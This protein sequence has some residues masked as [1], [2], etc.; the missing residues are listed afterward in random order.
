MVTLAVIEIGLRF[1]VDHLAPERR[2]P[3]SA[4]SVLRSLPGSGRVYGLRPGIAPPIGINS[5]GFRGPDVSRA[6]PA[7]VF[8]I[9]M[10]GDSITYGNSVQWDQTFSWRLEEQ[11]NRRDTGLRFE[12]LNLGV[13]GYN[14]RQELAALRELGL[15]LDPDLIVLNVCLN[16]SDPEKEMYGIALK[17][18]TQIRSWSDIN[19]RTIVDSSYLLTLTKH[20]LIGLL[21][22]S[23][24]SLK[25]L[26]SPRLF[27]DTRVGETAWAEM[28]A[29]MREMH[30]LAR[31]ARIP[32]AAVIYPYSS[33]L[34]LSDEERVPQQ[35]LLR[36]FR[37]LGVPAMEPIPAYRGA[38]QSMFVDGYIH[39][40]PL[41]H[42]R[43]ARAIQDFLESNRLLPTA[44]AS[45]IEGT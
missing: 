40:S 1:Y 45:R 39:L 3:E 15:Q 31:A 23:A 29:A 6:K 16:D 8:R 33:Q 11:L 34:E 12:V 18:R 26:N 7:G 28:K 21:Q 19:I 30:A 20:E 5:L 22:G 41:G 36:F 37:A 2:Q 38:E 17:N 4:V 9:L 27:L 44:A 14:T 42:E 24:T 43:V 10:L 35:D 25:A 13:S 32:M